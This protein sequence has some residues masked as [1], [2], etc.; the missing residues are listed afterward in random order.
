ML[1]NIYVNQNDYRKNTSDK[2][3]ASALQLEINFG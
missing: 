1:A 2:E 3:K